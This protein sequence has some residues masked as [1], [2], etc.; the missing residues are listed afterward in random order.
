MSK[1]D[2]VEEQ[3]PHLVSGVFQ[4][5]VTATKAIEQLLQE[6]GL[7]RGQIDLIKPDDELL[8]R[9]VEPEVQGIKRTLVRSHVVLGAAGLIV[10]LTLASLLAVFGPALTR[11]S[12][13][14][15]FIALVPMA[16]FVGLMLGG[17]VSL[18]PDH[19]PVIAQT[20]NASDSGNWSVIV[21][22]KDKQQQ[23]RANSILE[24]TTSHH[25]Q[26]L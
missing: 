6:Q 9:K 7:G 5:R 13:I 17:L 12:P 1:F 3:N 21:H 2:I 11:S 25:S 23:Q 10:G 14:M 4:S 8:A 19:D 20:R 16:T 22:C 18:R 24:N 26:S 15:T